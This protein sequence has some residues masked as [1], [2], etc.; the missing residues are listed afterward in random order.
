MTA[1][2]SGL[3]GGDAVDRALVDEGALAIDDEAVRGHL[4]VVR[5]ADA[6]VGVLDDGAGVVGG[7]LELVA[8]GVDD[9]PDGA[10]GD[11]FLLEFLHLAA[12]V[13][14]LHERAAGVIPFEDDGLALEVGEADGLAVEGLAGEVRSRLADFR[15]GE[16]DD[17]H[18]AGEEGGEDTH[19]VEG[20]SCCVGVDSHFSTPSRAGGS[21]N[22]SKP[23]VFTWF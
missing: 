16:R 14:L 17:G 23:L 7:G 18:E 3:G 10:G 6:L 2:V 8:A 1:D 9:E 5:A 15:S 22:L 13:E 12:F 19:G 4:G 20:R 21:I 11:D